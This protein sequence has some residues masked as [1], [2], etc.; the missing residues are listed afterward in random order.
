[1]KF[2]TIYE[3]SNITL[4]PASRPVSCIDTYFFTEHDALQQLQRFEESDRYAVITLNEKYRVSKMAFTISLPDEYS[5][6]T[7]RELIADLNSG[8]VESPD[9]DAYM[10]GPD[11]EC[12][13]YSE[14]KTIE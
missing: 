8:K 2:V 9:Y 6:T 1:M 5:I 11:T 10:C 14:M 12:L 4:D 3:I 13:L 7:A